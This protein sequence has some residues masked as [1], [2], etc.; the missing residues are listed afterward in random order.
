[1]SDALL[2]RNGTIQTM[3]PAQPEV[4]AFAVIGDRIVAVGNRRLVADA[5]PRGYR[6]VDLA[7]RCAVPG[8]NEAHNHMISYGTT[9][10]H[11]DAGFPAVKSIRDIVAAV[12][13]RAVATAKEQWIIGRG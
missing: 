6:T 8:F 13:E 10:E 2:V 5:L 1:M 11:I 3:D 4:E 7:G 9:L 12:R